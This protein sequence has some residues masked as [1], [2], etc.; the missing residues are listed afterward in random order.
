[1]I[2]LKSFVKYHSLGNDFI[3]FDW[4]K[5]PSAFMLHELHDLSWKKFVVDTCDRHR[6]VGA[7]CV[8]I[9]TNSTQAS[10]PEMLVF[11]ADGTQA[12]ISLNGIR[13]LAQYLF[14]QH[15]FPTSFSIKAGSRIVQLTMQTTSGTPAI[16]EIIT[17]VGPINYTGTTTIQTAHGTFDGHIVD[18]GNPH[19]IIFAQQTLEWLTNNGTEIESHPTFPAKTNVEFIWQTGDASLTQKKY[20]VLVY[21]RGCGITLACSSG[22][23]A[24]TGLLKSLNQIQT[25]QKISLD[26]PGGSVTTW[27][28]DKNNVILQAQAHFVFKGSL[29]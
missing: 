7:D 23:A 8:L 20:T 13:C 22:A 3:I 9:V 16:N 26:M 2:V 12:E 10:M 1:M 6:G 19:F 18:V 24:I 15:N 27:V 28:D 17:T 11:N 5:R 4:Y 14:T 29:E 21:E 25:N